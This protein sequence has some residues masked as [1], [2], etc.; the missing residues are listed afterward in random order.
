LQIRHLPCNPITKREKNKGPKHDSHNMSKL[1]K[2]KREKNKGP[3][4]D[5]HTFKVLGFNIF[6]EIYSR[7]KFFVFLFF[8]LFL[9]FAFLLIF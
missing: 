3:K 4:H 5:S 7:I 2:T 9:L 8:A 6:D 1:P